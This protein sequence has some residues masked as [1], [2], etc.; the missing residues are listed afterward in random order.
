MHA[1]ALAPWQT[2][3]PRGFEAGPRSLDSGSTRTDSPTKVAVIRCRDRSLHVVNPKIQTPSQLI[4][5]ANGQVQSSDGW[6][7][8][9]INADLLEYACGEAICL[10]NV[11]HPTRHRVRPIYASE[12]LSDLFP[13][14]R[15]NVSLA[16]PYLKGDFVVV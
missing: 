15:E 6:A 1:S 12:S 3:E 2:P 14:L 13:D 11:G 8:R 7:L 16:L 4:A 5:A 10:I 9:P